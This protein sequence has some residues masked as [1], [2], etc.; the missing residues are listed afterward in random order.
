MIESIKIAG[1]IT[2]KSIAKWVLI[3]FLGCL[4]TLVTFLVAFFRNID[5]VEGESQKFSAFFYGL[6]TENFPAL[7]LIFGAPIF[8][9]IYFIMANKISVQNVIFLLFRSKAGDYII[10]AIT[11]A[12]EKI[13]GKKGWHS[14]LISKGLVKAKVLQAVKNDPNTSKIQRSIIR[15]GFKKINLEDVDF[16]SE[17]ANLPRVMSDK[18]RHFFEEMVRPSL[19]FFWILILVQICLFIYSIF[20]G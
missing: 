3:V 12:V 11:T 4:V 14:D 1:T 5:L 9:I 10:S 2:L 16:Q 20:L 7:I 17:E 8:V 6:L 13:T 15:Y 18:F 19:M